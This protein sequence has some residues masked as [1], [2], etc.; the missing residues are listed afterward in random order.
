MEKQR[1]N[2]CEARKICAMDGGRLPS[3]RVSLGRNEG[4]ARKEV[5][6]RQYNEVLKNEKHF[7]RGA[8]L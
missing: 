1:K 8:V 4:K 7:L 5:V 2:A 3:V 6:T